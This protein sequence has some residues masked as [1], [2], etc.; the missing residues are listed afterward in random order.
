[1]LESRRILVPQA[2]FFQLL[3]KLLFTGVDLAV[4]RRQSLL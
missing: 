3:S 1:M 4:T 2:P